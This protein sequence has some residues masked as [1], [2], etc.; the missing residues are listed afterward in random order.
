MDNLPVINVALTLFI[1]ISLFLRRKNSVE[2]KILTWLFVIWS[3]RSILHFFV[4]DHKV[5][6]ALGFQNVTL[7][8]AASILVYIRFINKRNFLTLKSLLLYSPMILHLI[9]TLCYYFINSSEELLNDYYYLRRYDESG[10]YGMSIEK[11]IFLLMRAFIFSYFVVLSIKEFLSYKKKQTLHQKKEILWLKVLIG[12]WVFIYFV[13]DLL[14]FT[15]SSSTFLTPAFV[16]FFYQISFSVLIIVLGVKG[17][18]NN[19][20]NEFYVS[21]NQSVVSKKYIKSGLRDEKIES[22]FLTIKTAIID[23]ELYLDSELSLN[24][25]SN[26]I[27][28]STNIISQVINTKANQNFY[29]F[30]NTYRLEKVKEELITSD[31]TILQIAYSSGFNS[32]STFNAFFKKTTGMTPS[33]YRK[34]LRGS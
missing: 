21:S 19:F 34:K 10:L 31:E 26:H 25:L 24:D 6:A 2:I 32:K 17:L 29:D 3:I 4:V 30:I 1:L 23:K 11:V 9:L 16:S 8:E 28:V 22:V 20:Q 5:E 12:T 13:P 33:L 27:D 18:N 15:Y 14:C 7:L